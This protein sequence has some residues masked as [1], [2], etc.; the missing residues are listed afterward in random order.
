MSDRIIGQVAEILDALDPRGLPSDT[1]GLPCHSYS[2]SSKIFSSFVL[3]QSL[4]AWLKIL[5]RD[6]GIEKI[7]GTTRKISAANSKEFGKAIAPFFDSEEKKRGK[8]RDEETDE[9][10]DD[11]GK[12]AVRIGRQLSLS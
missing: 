3:S 8:T 4:T 9:K 1:P 5:A 2:R 12:P 11:S 6:P 10:H 7:L